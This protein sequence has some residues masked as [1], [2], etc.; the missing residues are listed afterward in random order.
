MMSLLKFPKQVR[1][2]LIAQPN[3]S[4]QAWPSSSRSRLVEKH[5][6][7]VSINSGD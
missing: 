3:D 5:E 2:V 7:G 4:R 1:T 6:G